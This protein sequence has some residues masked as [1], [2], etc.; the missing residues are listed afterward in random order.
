VMMAGSKKRALPTHQKRV[1]HAARTLRHAG[2][3][4]GNLGEGSIPRQA[5]LFARHPRFHSAL[6]ERMTFRPLLFEHIVE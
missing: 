4:V 1:D 3:I 2:A 5:H 6:G